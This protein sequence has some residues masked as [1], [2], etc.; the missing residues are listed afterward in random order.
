MWSCQP[1]QNRGVVHIV[2]FLPSKHKALSIGL[3]TTKNSSLFATQAPL[4]CNPITLF[5]YLYY[6]KFIYAALR[7]VCILHL[8]F[9]GNILKVKDGGL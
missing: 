4:L 8:A 5:V 3:S 1:N 2:E 9:C 7:I 6:E